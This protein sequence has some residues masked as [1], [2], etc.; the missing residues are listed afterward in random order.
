MPHYAYQINNNA[1][2]NR[3]NFILELHY[4]IHFLIAMPFTKNKTTEFINTK[5]R[6]NKTSNVYIP[7]YVFNKII[8]CVELLHSVRI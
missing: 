1:D 7:E 6:C 4:F 5:F 8:D 2:I 3:L